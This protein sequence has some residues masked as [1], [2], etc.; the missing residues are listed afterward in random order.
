MSSDTRFLP[1]A[2]DHE[3]L[4]TINRKERDSKPDSVEYFEVRRASG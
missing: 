2:N 1:I 4:C 3:R